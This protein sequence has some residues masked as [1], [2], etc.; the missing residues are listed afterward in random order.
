MHQQF[1][2]N[3]GKSKEVELTMQ[4]IANKFGISVEQLKIKK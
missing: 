1:R 4:E 2:I 3:M